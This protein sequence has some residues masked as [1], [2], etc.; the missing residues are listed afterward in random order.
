MFSVNAIIIY[1]AFYY[2]NHSSCHF[3]KGDI[4]ASSED[5]EFSRV[6]L[7]H[8][9]SFLCWA[10]LLGDIFNWLLG[11]LKICISWD[12]TFAEA[13]VFFS[14]GHTTLFAWKP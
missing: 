2:T 4:R 13:T 10:I 9:A 3:T 1:N 7:G 12:T 11:E 14:T 8:W 5:Q 6:H